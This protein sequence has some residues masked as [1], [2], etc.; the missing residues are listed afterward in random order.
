MEGLRSHASALSHNKVLQHYLGRY[1]DLRRESWQG[2]IDSNPALLFLQ[3]TC[4]EYKADALV[5][6]ETRADE[7][8]A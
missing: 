4:K 1:H 7:K 8:G 6:D 3:Q 5:E 2:I